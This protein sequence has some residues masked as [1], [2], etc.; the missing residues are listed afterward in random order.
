MHLRL[1]RFN[2]TYEDMNI[3]FRWQKS[4]RE[5]IDQSSI[6]HKA[7]DMSSDYITIITEQDKIEDVDLDEFEKVLNGRWL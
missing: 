2:Y 1:N 7:S 4:T 5:I 6:S 3:N